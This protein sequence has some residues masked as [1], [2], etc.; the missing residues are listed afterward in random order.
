PRRQL[1]GGRTRGR[2][3]PGAS[4]MGVRRRGPRG[5]RAAHLDL[6]V[7]GGR[8]LEGV[9]AAL[10]GEWGA[11]TARDELAH[12]AFGWRS[13]PGG[14]LLMRAGTRLAARRMAGRILLVIL[15]CTA[16]QGP[17]HGWVR[18]LA[19]IPRPAPRPNRALP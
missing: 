17:P 1:G 10:P 9:P 19:R 6:S 18:R 5:R 15:A 7:A 8:R 3:L 12:R 4:R 13:S 16:P 11:T 14:Q 2:G